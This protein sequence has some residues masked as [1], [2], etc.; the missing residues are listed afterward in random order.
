MPKQEIG[1]LAFRAE[2]EM[3]NAYWVP[4]MGS[5]DGAL[6]IGFVRLGLAVGGVKESF[7][8]TMRGAFEVAAEDAIGQTPTWSKP[9]VAPESERGGNA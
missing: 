3:W 1:R 2:G 6:L 5:M 7:M 4:T 8:A 9:R